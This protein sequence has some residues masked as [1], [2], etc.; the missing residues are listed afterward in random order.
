M[1]VA[2]IFKERYGKEENYF[3]PVADY[4]GETKIVDELCFDSDGATYV[5]KFDGEKSAVDS[6]HVSDLKLIQFDSY[7]ERK[8]FIDNFHASKKIDVDKVSP[9]EKLK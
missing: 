2:N 5:G 4:R 8:E 9:N 6:D 1:K 3:L 7:K